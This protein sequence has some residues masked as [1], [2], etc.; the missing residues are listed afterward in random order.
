LLALKFTVTEDQSHLGLIPPEFQGLSTANWHSSAQTCAPL[1]MHPSFTPCN[2]HPA[3]RT[4]SASLTAFCFLL[5]PCQCPALC[6][7]PLAL[8][9]CPVLQRTIKA[10]LAC[11]RLS[12]ACSFMCCHQRLPAGRLLSGIARCQSCFAAKQHAASAR[13]WLELLHAVLTLPR[14]CCSALMS[15]VR[16]TSS[17]SLLGPRAQLLSPAIY[18]GGS[19]FA[20]RL[21]HAKKS[22]CLWR[23]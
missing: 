20:V 4:Q 8:A 10:Q 6:L 3:C 1:P 19:C 15:Q 17:S 11:F 7:V 2:L 14:S 22:A 21:C 5:S 23:L 9:I 18:V 13:K 12:A 16:R